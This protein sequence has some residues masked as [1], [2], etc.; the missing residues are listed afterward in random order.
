MRSNFNLM[1]TYLTGTLGSLAAGFLRTTSG[2]YKWAFVLNVVA[3]AVTAIA[4]MVKYFVYDTKVPAKLLA[5]DGSIEK[6]CLEPHSHT[7]HH[8]V[9]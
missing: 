5:T 2:S 4:G 6:V 9:V 3:F 8:V 1:L 7:D